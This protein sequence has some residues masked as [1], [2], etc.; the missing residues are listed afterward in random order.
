MNRSPDTLGGYRSE[1]S[2]R[3]FTI[4][5]GVLGSLFFVVQVV[6]PMAVMLVAMPAALPKF[7]LTRYEIEGATSFRGRIHLVRSTLAAPDS[8]Q[9]TPP[10]QLVRIDGDS[11]Q[12]LAS[13]TGS[14]PFLLGDDRQL[15]LI[16]SARVGVFNG[17]A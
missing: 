3:T 7:A 17:R 14:R 10:A 8:K 16:S 11:V 6:A 2:K 9:D 5:V 15:W 12:E 13:L 1:A 4:V